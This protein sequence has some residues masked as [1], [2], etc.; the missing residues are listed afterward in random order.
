VRSTR[1][2][3]R[4]LRQVALV[5]GAVALAA[6]TAAAQAG[7]AT[8]TGAIRDAE[9]GAPVEGASVQVR[10]T[11]LTTVTNGQ[12]QFTM[13]G[14]PTSPHTLR[15]IAIGYAADS[16]PGLTLQAGETRTLAL[17]L[18][19]TPLDLQEIVVTASRLSERRAETPASVA[20]LPF[21]EILSRN[22]TTINHALEFVPGVTFNGPDQM[23]IRG[24]TGFARG[25]GS[26]VLML[27]DG[28][29]A[30]SADGGEINFRALPVIDLARTEVV[31]GAYSALYGS[32]A[33]GGVVN[34]ITTPVDDRPT[35]AARAHFDAYDVPADYQWSNGL[36]NSQGL[37]LQHSRRLGPL[38]A[39]AFVGYQGT[40]GY[41]QNGQN[42]IWMARVKFQAL[43]TATHQWDAFA[44]YTNEKSQ[45]FLTWRA[46]SLPFE[47]SPQF[48]G[49]YA[50]EQVFLS[51]ATVAAIATAKTLLKLSPFLTWNASQNEFTANQDHHAAIKPGLNAALTRSLSTRNS[52]TVGGDAAYTWV[53]SN[54]IGTPRIVDA[55]VFVQ[56]EARL[57]ANLKGEAGFRADYHDASTAQSEFVVSPKVGA[58]LRLSSSITM[59]SSIGAGYR[60][61]SA[62]EQFVN[63]FQ[64]GFQVLPNPTLQGE[65]SWSAEIGTSAVLWNRLQVD[66][67]VFGSRYSNLIGPAAIQ[68]SSPLTFQ[69]QNIASAQVLGLDVG[70][71]ATINPRWLNLAATF[72]YLDSK[73]LDT[74]QPLPY[75]S[76]VNITGTVTTLQGH[77][78]IDVRY[79]TA[80]E[81]VLA[82]PL[83]ARQNILV[84]DLRLDYRLVGV[85]WQLKVSN[86]F[87]TFYTNVLER[88]PG[89]P[90]MIGLTAVYGL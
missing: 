87:N 39:R 85:L 35:T 8:L 86:L 61:P 65:R 26:R 34:L 40:D 45:E 80:V 83:D 6:S 50:R 9:T 69:F 77:A 29:P 33:L 17:A 22:V 89:A 68:G 88:N 31:K 11:L 49:D 13:T 66:A 30:I 25:V 48:L 62:I 43:P 24:S 47:V 82:Y 57:G 67:A 21:S 15:V 46:D 90:R 19:R 37:E 73:D 18:H 20:V 42:H 54:F 78:G 55:A 3:S 72:L 12:G 52:L 59:R 81:E 58:S 1:R 56:D 28:H 64:F 70:A 84:F 38:G 41:T 5:A 51:G 16:L 76:Q 71:N 2:V 75:R 32:N 4:L 7:T 74:G 23:D 53:S 63:T 14:V 10:G 60:A 27:L 36:L 79:R 44:L